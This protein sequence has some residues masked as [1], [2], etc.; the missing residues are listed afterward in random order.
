MT[1]ARRAD[2][3]TVCGGMRIARIAPGP[4]TLEFLRLLPT[5][6]RDAPNLLLHYFAQYGDVVRLG[7]RRLWPVFLLNDPQH[8][9]HV[10]QDNYMNY[11]KG[12][13]YNELRRM[14]GDGL[15][16]AEG[17]EWHRQR[18]Q[19]QPAFYSDHEPEFARIIVEATVNLLHEWDAVAESGRALDIREEMRNLTLDILLRSLFGTELA[20]HGATL[21]P[22]LDT[23]EQRIK[24]A[25]GFNPFRSLLNRLP[26]RG[27]LKLRK[28]LRNI[29]SFAYGLIDERRRC[30]RQ[31]EDVLSLLVGEGEKG[32][33]LD[34]R[35]IRNAMVTLVDSGYD[36]TANAIAWAWYLLSRNPVAARKLYCEVRDVLGGRAP[37][38]HDL[39]RMVY[40]R[41][42]VQETLRIY[43]SAWVIARTAIADDNIDG[44]HVP[45]KTVL[46]MSPYAAHRRAASWENPEGFDPERFSRDRSQ[47]RHPFSYF[48]FGGGPRL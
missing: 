29:D 43:P 35:Q 9:K 32:A 1:S 7:H 20:V 26:T 27:N 34:D 47:G 41:M 40:T 19:T 4:S 48:P 46:I 15:V 5:L 17:E 24:P 38:F 18:R 12:S 13:L 16:T 23:A 33:R 22:A 8:I 37:T 44:Y 6:L 31:Q 30:P 3:D 2:L 14:H 45:A 39:P 10:L 42:V 36:S 21:C 28:A 25:S 11:S